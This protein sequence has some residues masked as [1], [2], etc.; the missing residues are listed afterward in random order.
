MLSQDDLRV[1]ADQLEVDQV[2]GSVARVGGTD[3]PSFIV[4]TAFKEEV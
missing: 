2:H 1:R 4:E 3:V